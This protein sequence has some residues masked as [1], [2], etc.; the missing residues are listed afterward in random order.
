M[1]AVPAQEP[2]ATLRVGETLSLH[3]TNISL[4]FVRVE[5]DSRCPKDAR[6]IR[7]GEAVVVLSV[8][9]ER[10]GVSTLTFEVPPGGGAAQNFQNYRI[11]IIGLDPQ[12]EADVEIASTDYVATIAGQQR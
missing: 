3:G 12:A 2:P 1:V 10:G 9:Q 6:C 5:R 7:A 11:Q 4:T 8:R